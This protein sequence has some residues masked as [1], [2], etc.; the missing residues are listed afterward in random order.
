MCESN[1]VEPTQ[2]SAAR[3]PTRSPAGSP[4]RRRDRPE[5][6][7][8]PHGRSAA[9]SRSIGR[10]RSQGD[11]MP[12]IRSAARSGHPRGYGG[13]R[14]GLRH[15]HVGGGS[16]QA[17]A[18]G[19]LEQHL[20]CALVVRGH[21]LSEQLDLRRLRGRRLLDRR[22]PDH[23]FPA[24][25]PEPPAGAS[26]AFAGRRR[27]ALTPADR[28]LTPSWHGGQGREGSR[29]RRARRRH[30]ARADAARS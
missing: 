2:R 19:E 27:R 16:A 13:H 28:F 14:R 30:R 15:V 21:F 6:A 23:D 11:R 29:G 9:K 3:S 17:R 18:G 8:R 22:L 1:P 7:R 20:V 10:L 25:R 24:R 26:Q 4:L 12:G 5:P